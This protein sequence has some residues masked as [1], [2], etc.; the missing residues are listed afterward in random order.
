MA[1]RTEST[2]GSR[3]GMDISVAGTAPSVGLE[4]RRTSRTGLT[5]AHGHPTIQG[6]AIRSPDKSWGCICTCAASIE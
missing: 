1:F 4:A 3:Y 5:C 6:E 2:L